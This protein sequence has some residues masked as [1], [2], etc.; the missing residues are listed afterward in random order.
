MYMDRRTPS[1]SL[2]RTVRLK[3]WPSTAAC[4]SPKPTCPAQQQREKQQFT[5]MVHGPKHEE[6]PSMIHGPT[7]KPTRPDQP[8]QLEEDRNPILFF[9][10]P[11]R[12]QRC[13]QLRSNRE[14]LEPALGLGAIC[15]VPTPPREPIECTSGAIRAKGTVRQQIVPNLAPEEAAPLPMALLQPSPEFAPPTV[16]TDSHD[17]IARK[18]HGCPYRATPP[19][20]WNSQSSPL[21]PLRTPITTA[22][23]PGRTARSSSGWACSPTTLIPPSCFKGWRHKSRHRCP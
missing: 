8:A 22:A 6:E 4:L 14:L 21:P 10:W 23:L 18:S 16:E 3:P 17:R 9:T 20:K 13:S 1:R 5:C 7:W 12:Q 2:E 11:R 15:A 19:W